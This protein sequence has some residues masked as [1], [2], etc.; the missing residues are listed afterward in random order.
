MR[1]D[2]FIVAVG[3]GSR[4]EAKLLVKQ[5]RISVN[6]ECVVKS[7]LV[8]DEEKDIVQLDGN[9]LH[10]QACYYV[11]LNKPQGVISATEDKYERTVLDLLDKKYHKVFPVGRL[12]K[13]T[14][15]LLLLTNDGQLAHQ[16][17]SP[18]KHVDKVY[19]VTLK[20][21]IEASAVEQF[22]QGIVL[23]DGYRCLPANLV[24]NE[25]DLHTVQV[26]I[27][28][29]KFH[30]VKRM[31]EAIENKVTALKRERMGTLV[32]D[33]TLPLGAYRE[34]TDEERQALLASVKQ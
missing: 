17:L 11:M 31:F 34:L 3:A 32:L 33:N 24:L 6:G 23:K 25:Q 5:K 19:R 10:Y 15:G 14:T 1:L 18:K 29:G 12:D 21:P 22:H 27:H 2:K 26:T 30:Q 20:E 4:K 9:I 16:L 28:E 8:I 7:D 13:D